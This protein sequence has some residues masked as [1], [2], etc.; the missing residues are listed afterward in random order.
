MYVPHVSRLVRRKFGRTDLRTGVLLTRL[1]MSPTICPI[2]RSASVEQ[3]LRDALLFAHIDGLLCTST[4]VIVYHCDSG[5]V[6]MIVEDDSGWNE[7]VPEI[8][9]SSTLVQ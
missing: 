6:F 9:G 7:V 8:K 1:T 5:H 4:E 3:M 2:C